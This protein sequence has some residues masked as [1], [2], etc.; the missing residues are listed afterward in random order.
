M[1]LR[2]VIGIAIALGLALAWQSFSVWKL[3]VEATSAA[4]TIERFRQQYAEL[5][6]QN[7]GLAANLERLR[8]DRAAIEEVRRL[9][10]QQRADH[11][12]ERIEFTAELR[13]ALAAD[14]ADTPCAVVPVPDA[15]ADRL[16]SARDRANSAGA[17][18]SSPVPGD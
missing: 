4:E 9:L 17:L 18:P 15:A 13:E 6:S 1:I 10:E 7:D 12:R 3:K 11:E 16:R 14:L 8:Q 5:E 2:V